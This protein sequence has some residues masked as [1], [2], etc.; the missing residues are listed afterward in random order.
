[1]TIPE[2]IKILAGKALKVTVIGTVSVI[3]SDNYTCTVKPVQEDMADILDVKIQ[4]VLKPSMG[5]RIIPK[6]GSYVYVTMENETSGYISLYSEIEKIE[7][8]DTLVVVNGGKNGGLIK[9]NTFS[10]EL[11]KTN[12]AVNLILQ[13]L[14]SWVPVASDGGAALKTL[15][16]SNLSSSTVGDFSQIEDQ[17]IKI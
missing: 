16:T 1:M 6:V 4:P 5:I 17:T 7:I 11:E 10:A 8:D 12:Q 15:V 3:D 9:Y 14:N 2:A 13:T